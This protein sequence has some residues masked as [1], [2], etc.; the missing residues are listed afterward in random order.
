MLRT[1]LRLPSGPMA[2]ALLA[3]FLNL[4]GMGYAAT[5]GNFLIGKSNQAKTTTSLVGSPTSGVALKVKNLTSGSPAA[6][7][8]ASNAQPFTVSSTT[9]VSNL[10]ADLFDG[11]DSAAF[12]LKSNNVRI[13]APGI[14]FGS[15]QQNWD[16][17][18]SITLIANCYITPD[19]THHFDQTL[20]NNAPGA[21]EFHVAAQ[22]AKGVNPL[23]PIE[24][25]GVV[26]SGQTALVTQAANPSSSNLVGTSNIATLIWRDS[27]ETITAT[28][29]AILYASYCSIEGTLTRTT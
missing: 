4:A 26:Q 12:Q 8:V 21:G 27:G 19:G 20:L 2:V 29:S 25:D 11:L 23:T 22:I 9:K 18:P 17:G 28:Y 7:F 15:Q 10:N 14:N 24:H 1:R 13:D 5:G 16:I 6:A 3:L